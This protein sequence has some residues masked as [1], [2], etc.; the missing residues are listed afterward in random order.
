MTQK[1]R[2]QKGLV[3]MSMDENIIR[4][5]FRYM[6]VLYRY[7][8]TRPTQQKK[9]A[10]LIRKMFAEVGENCYFEPPL[11][12]NFG[13]RH[14]HAGNNVYTNYG[15]TFVDDTDIYIGDYV[16]MAPYVVIATAAH[17]I[18]PKLREYAMQF[19][20]PVHIGNNVWIGAGAV[21]LPGVTIGENSVIGAGS[22]V[23]RDIPAN[24]VAVGNPCRVLRAIGERDR[25]YFFKEERYDIPPEEIIDEK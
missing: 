8:H 22:V 14:V 21:V 6:D 18:L 25:V 20:R 11:N 9:R 4:E 23:T 5:Q 12:S 3:Y 10:R 17:P 15:V 19:N 24:V 1:E 13:C 2:M 7:N 16:M